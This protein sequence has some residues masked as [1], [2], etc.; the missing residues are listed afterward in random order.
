M[1]DRSWQWKDVIRM[2]LTIIP[3]FV[4]SIA[5]VY[6]LHLTNFQIGNRLQSTGGQQKIT[7]ACERNQELPVQQWDDAS[8][9]VVG[10]RHINLEEIAAEQTAGRFVMEVYRKDPNVNI[11][12]EIYQ[13][14]WALVKSHPIL[15][16]GWGSV[17]NYLGTDER[18]AGLNASNIFLEVWLGAGLL[19]LVSF[20]FLLGY[21]LYNSSWFFLHQD[22]FFGLFLLLGLTAIVIPNL[23]NSGIFLG[24]VWLFLGLACI[25]R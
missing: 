7:V 18:G 25:K 19:G 1:N 6:F 21:I 5:S 23:F 10:C 17:S 8:L 4:L 3:L 12:A 16:I 11:R 22:Q 20:V 2:K 24:F 15:G 9:A 14:S 13:K